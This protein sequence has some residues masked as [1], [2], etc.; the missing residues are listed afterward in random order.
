MLNPIGVILA[1]N[2]IDNLNQNQINLNQS[3][4][5]QNRPHLGQK[6]KEHKE[7]L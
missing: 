6:D 5:N 4:L 7:P 1:F 2:C 3:N